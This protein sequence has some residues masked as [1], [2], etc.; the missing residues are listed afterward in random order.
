MSLNIQ[1]Y[2]RKP[3]TI[4]AIQITVDN[5]QEVAEWCGG[6]I[7]LEKHGGRLVQYIKVDVAHAISERQKKAFVEDWVLKAGTGFKCYSKRAFPNNFEPA[8]KGV[9]ADELLGYPGQ[10]PLFQNV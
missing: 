10:D 8:K 1:K 6:E 4:D 9:T 7:I 3:F 5:M 2:Q